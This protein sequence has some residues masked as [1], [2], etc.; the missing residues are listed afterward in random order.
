[1]QRTLCALSLFACAST[2]AVADVT[3]GVGLSLPGDAQIRTVKYDCSGHDPITVQYLDAAPNFLALLP[4]DG[5]SVVFAKTDTA[6]GAKYE[7]GKYVWWSKNSQATLSDITEGLDAAPV[8]SCS[9]E[10][11]TP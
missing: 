7:A 11:D 4:I 10:N 8:L 5:Q 9:E 2:P 6:S 1:M 3:F